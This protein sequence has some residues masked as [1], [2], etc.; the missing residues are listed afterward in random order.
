MTF[1]GRP[2][3]RLID[4]SDQVAALMHEIAPAMSID[5]HRGDPDR[6][7]L[8]GM[9]RDADIVLNGHTYLDADLIAAAE[10]LSGIVFLGSGAASY[11]DMNAAQARG[12]PVRAISNYGD[13][14]VAQHTL[15][16]VLDAVRHVSRMDRDLRR[17]KW[18]TLEGREFGETTLGVIGLGG[19]GR[20]FADLAARVG[21]KVVAWNRSA[22]EP[23]AQVAMVTLD[24]LLA[25]S[26]IVSMHLGYS[27]ETAG[28]L[29]A[30]KL[31][32]LRKG[33]ILVNTARAGLIDTRAM[34]AALDAGHLGHTALDVFDHEP[35]DP[36]G[37]AG[38]AGRYD[39]DGACRLQDPLGHAPSP[40]A[41]AEGN[42]HSTG[43]GPSFRRHDIT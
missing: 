30:G 4:A 34:I 3:I 6:A 23:P 9:L 35:L 42:S 31:M 27:A 25:Q 41:G 2:R 5:I 14:A 22:V 12:I 10:H 20:C 7:T 29:D 8:S 26:D 19:I 15:A 38:S 16:L 32:Q 33:A 40:G 13:A 21:F 18:Q 28:F 17:G 11:I 39:A 37:A 1:G 24:S 43:R 36:R